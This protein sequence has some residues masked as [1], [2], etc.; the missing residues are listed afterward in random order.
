MKDDVSREV[1]KI[2]K[3]TEIENMTDDEIIEK[4][5]ADYKSSIVKLF[6]GVFLGIMGFVIPIYFGI[7][8][9]QGALAVFGIF[10]MFFLLIVA[11]ILFL[12]SINGLQAM[13][14]YRLSEK[15]DKIDL[16]ETPFLSEE[17]LE[18]RLLELG[19]KE[20]K[21]GFLLKKGYKFF[22]RIEDKKNIYSADNIV[23]AMQRSISKLEKLGLG[24][25]GEIAITVIYKDS[26]SDA[27]MEENEALAKL[28]LLSSYESY[29]AEVTSAYIILDREKQRGYFAPKILSGIYPYTHGAKMLERIFMANGKH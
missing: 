20:T 2:N 11:L 27:F 4:L 7:K 25:K 16:V 14:Y 28:H 13:E 9:I 24:A 17:E 18:A 6:L 22:L 10:L 12:C 21:D 26:V 1:K 19:F 29:D 23:S 3:K 5:E 15:I 8:D